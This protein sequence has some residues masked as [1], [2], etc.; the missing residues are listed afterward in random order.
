MAKC[1]KW[2]GASAGGQWCQCAATHVFVFSNEDPDRDEIPNRFRC[3]LH[4]RDEEK[5]IRPAISYS[6]MTIEEY[7]VWQVHEG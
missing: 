2:L 4:W 5:F 1:D 6:L 3:S 7:K